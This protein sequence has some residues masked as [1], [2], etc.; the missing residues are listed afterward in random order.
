VMLFLK[1]PS[2]G[3]LVYA[4]NP[5][6]NTFF[7]IAAIKAVGLMQ[8]QTDVHEAIENLSDFSLRRIRFLI[9]EAKANAPRDQSITYTMRVLSNIATIGFDAGSTQVKLKNRNVSRAAAEFLTR[10]ANRREWV[11][12]TVNE[13]PVPLKETWSWLC[14]NSLAITE[15]EVWRHFSQNKMV[16]VLKAED[17]FLNA[18]GL[19]SSSQDGD[20]YTVAGIEVVLLAQSP[21]DLVAD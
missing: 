5:E 7:S 19:R 20:R 2:S 12:A 4:L 18:L 16:T 17:R 3:R 13:H 6:R 14:A 8:T 10:C 21:S 15:Q 11:D 9:G 1:S